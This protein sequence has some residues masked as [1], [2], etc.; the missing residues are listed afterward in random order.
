MIWRPP[1][2]VATLPVTFAVGRHTVVVAR[3]DR[4]WTVSVD[5]VA[6][7]ATYGTEADA[8]EAGVRTADGLDRS[9]AR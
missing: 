1:V 8:W 6:A 3:Q 9:A 7:S 5:G 4:R 2:D